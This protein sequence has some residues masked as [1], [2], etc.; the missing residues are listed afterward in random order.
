MKNIQGEKNVPDKIPWLL[1]NVD[2]HQVFILYLLLD[3]FIMV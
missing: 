1:L 3:N 2:I